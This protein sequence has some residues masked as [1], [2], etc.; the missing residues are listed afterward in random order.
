MKIGV[1]GSRT[2][3]DKSKVFAVL[4][5]FAK[6]G[7]TIISGGAVGVDSFAYE[8]ATKNIYLTVEYLPLREKYQAESPFYARN[9][10]IAKACDILLAFPNKDS[11]GTWQTIGFSKKFGKRVIIFEGD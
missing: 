5:N 7:D 6:K 3:N 4:D 9:R 2:W 1:V 10:E 11:K 8:W